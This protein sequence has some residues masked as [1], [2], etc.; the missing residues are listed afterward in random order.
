MARGRWARAGSLAVIMLGACVPETASCPTGLTLAAD[1]RC[2]AEAGTVDGGSGRD[3]GRGPDGCALHVYHVD[4]D[5]DGFGD[6]A[7]SVYACEMPLGHVAMG[8]DCDD[9][10]A[11]CHPG[12]TEACEGAHDENCDGRVDEMCTCAEG[13]TQA[14]GMS[15]M[16]PCHRGT[17]T[18]S[19][20]R[21]GSCMGAVD[22]RPETCNTMD[23]DCDG[24]VDESVATAM[25]YVDA[26]GDGH[27]AMGGTPMLACAQPDGYAASSDDCDDT[28]AM[29]HPGAVEAC[30]GADDDCNGT[31]DDGGGFTCVMGASVSCPTSCGSTGTGTCSA[32]CTLPSGAAC[33]VPAET[34]NGLDENCDHLVDEGLGIVGAPATVTSISNH[35]SPHLVGLPTGFGV[36]YATGSSGQATWQTITSA[37]GSPSSPSPL[38]TDTTSFTYDFDA[39]F[40]GARVVVVGPS[41][42]DYALFAF[43]PGTGG[44]VLP[45]FVLPRGT[46]VAVTSV[47]IAR[48]SSGSVTVY[49]ALRNGT[50]WQ[51]RR[52]VLN[53]SGTVANV[54]DQDDVVTDLDGV[55]AWAVVASGS[56]EILVY[57]DAANDDVV[58]RSVS[59]AGVAGAA[60]VVRAVAD[61]P[62]TSAV[63]LGFRDPSLAVGTASPLAVVIAGAAGRALQYLQITSLSS[64]MGT[65]SVSLPGSFG[66]AIG[67][68]IPLRNLW[69]AA[70]AGVTGDAGLFYVAALEFES[71]GAGHYVLRA[72][73]VRSGA[74]LDPHALTVPSETAL[75]SLS[76]LTIAA[77]GTSLRVAEPTSTGGIVTRQLGC[78]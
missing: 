24:N 77:S 55:R 12:A 40:D 65:T 29:R 72:W 18:C 50:A 30:N 59:M 26:D 9:A 17:Q 41:G 48:I 64:P 1:G 66:A 73:E 69:V 45:L 28:S 23:D 75:T 42:S 61:A 3:A 56:G 14:C 20:G 49:G 51:L 52:W 58:L 46:L 78:R 22:P 13:A 57:R 60:S 53:T 70:P 7:S 74:P 67:G 25:Y 43:D 34:C 76:D 47:R 54:I 62:D 35:F 37:G 2:V 5:G 36:V 16:A 68:L 6:D 39:A 8:G 27:G 21:W 33:V 71:G 4:A 44:R 19:G 63:G 10:C 38:G 31:A 32:S 11:S 15:A